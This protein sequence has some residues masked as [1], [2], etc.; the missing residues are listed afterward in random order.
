MMKTPRTVRDVLQ[1]LGVLGYFR[2]FVRQYA[3]KAKPIY[4][5]IRAA[6]KEES[7]G[8]TLK[9]KAKSIGRA[10]VEWTPAA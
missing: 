1:V 8:K 3:D 5:V 9:Q 6:E 10:K 2:K 4:D 7:K